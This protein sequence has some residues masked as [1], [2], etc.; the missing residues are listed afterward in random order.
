MS[1]SHRVTTILFMFMLAACSQPASAPT[2]G[3]AKDFATACDKSNNGQR[4][5]VVG[6]LRFPDSFTGSDSVVLRLYEKD[7]YKGQPIG[8]QINFGDQPN[9]AAMVGDNYTDKDL[10]VHLANGQVAGYGTA[11]KVSGKVYYPAVAQD[12][13]CALENPLVETAQ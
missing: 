3:Q 9:Q 4:I 12:F 2:V 6:Y 13:P 11:V 5:A 1:L 10:Q 7:D 8:V